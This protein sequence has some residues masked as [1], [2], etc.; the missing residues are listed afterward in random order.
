ML[1]ESTIRSFLPLCLGHIPAFRGK[2]RITL[3]L[4]KVLTDSHSALSYEV[5]GQLNDGV[6]FHFDLRPWGQKFAYYYRDWEKGYVSVMRKLYS[7]GVFLDV[8]SS[9]GLYV[10]CMGETVRRFNGSIISIEPVPYNLERQKKNVALNQLEDLVTYVPVALGKELKIARIKTDLKGG[11]N[12]AF[13]TDVGDLEVMV[14]PLDNLVSESKLGR[15]G[16]MKIDIE[17][18]EPMLIEGAKATIERDQPIIFAE[19]CRE[20][21]EINGFSI[22]SAW[23]FLIEDQDYDCFF[24]EAGTQKLRPLKSPGFLENLFFIPKGAATQPDLFA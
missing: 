5:I 15:I 1:L 22:D 4:D 16:L 12:N 17:G 8:G 11:D 23:E 14:T 9:L 10:V 20:R 6:R 7:G 13:I 3:L 21:M 18:Y 19:F 24:L 2:G